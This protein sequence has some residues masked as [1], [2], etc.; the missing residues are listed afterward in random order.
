MTDP[1]PAKT[2]GQVFEG[3]A[4]TFCKAATIIALTG[5]F[6]LP[7]AAGAAAV[8]FLLADINGQKE[9][10]CFLMKPRLIAALWGVVAVVSL[11]WK[12]TW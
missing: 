3:L 5:K 8:F 6:A 12:L 7:A 1:K 4:F 10:R 2:R 11:W 9:T